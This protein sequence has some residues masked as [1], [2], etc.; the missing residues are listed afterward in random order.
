MGL[1]VVKDNSNF[2]IYVWLLPDGS[3]FKD[4][5]DNV[6]NIPSEKGN[7]EKIVEIKKAASYYGQPDGQAVFI[8]GIGRVTEEEY[9]EDKYRM[10]NGLLSYGDT[11][12]WRDAARTRRSL[13]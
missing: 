13:D 12:A 8:P 4:D 10:E 3:I 5:D 6:L 1:H 7:L 11:G 2:G 9:Q